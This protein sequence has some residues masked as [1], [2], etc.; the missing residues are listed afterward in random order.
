MLPGNIACDSA[1]SLKLGAGA[2]TNPAPTPGA[3]LLPLQIS[4]FLCSEGLV[5]SLGQVELLVLVLSGCIRRHWSLSLSRGSD[6]STTML[7]LEA[8]GKCSQGT[9]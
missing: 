5:L 1:A 6:P 8:G 7:V 3:A 9:T 2:T 4:A